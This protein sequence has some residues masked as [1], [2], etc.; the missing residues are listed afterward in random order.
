MS[1]ARCVWASFRWRSLFT[2]FLLQGTL[3]VLISLPLQRGVVGSGPAEA[4]PWEIAGFVLWGIGF[5]FEA[6]GDAQMRRFK[7]NPENAGRIMDRG[8]WRYTRHPN[9]FGDALL[10]WGFYLMVVPLPGGWWFGLSPLVMTIFLL[11][12]S[13]LALLEKNLLRRRPGYEEYIRTTSPFLPWPPSSP[14]NRRDR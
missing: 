1:R 9:Y 5:L 14:S 8:L 3:I 13:G 6:V 4:S 2:V 10:W 11:R 12:I 7:K